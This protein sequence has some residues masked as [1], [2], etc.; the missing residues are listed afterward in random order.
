MEP[1]LKLWLEEDGRLVMS[2][3]RARLLRHVRETGSLARAAAAMGLSYRRAWGKVREIEQNLGYPLVRSD[4]G[5]RGGGNSRLT[6]EGERLLERYEGFRADCDRSTG[7]LFAQWLAGLS[8]QPG[9]Q[10]ES[11]ADDTVDAAVHQA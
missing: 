3:Y 11:V 5:G 8:G 7:E 4:V 9:E 1:R 2:D 10:F 6:P